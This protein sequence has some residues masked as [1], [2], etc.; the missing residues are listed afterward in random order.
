MQDK[1]RKS[2]GSIDERDYSGPRSRECCKADIP[3]TQHPTAHMGDEAG[4][5]WEP[6][7]SRGRPL[8]NTWDAFSVDLRL[9]I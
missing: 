6:G 3:S 1:T 8:S 2:T 4:N 9:V 7:A 5:T